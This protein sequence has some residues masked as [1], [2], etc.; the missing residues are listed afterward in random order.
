MPWHILMYLVVSVSNYNFS[1]HACFINIVNNSLPLPSDSVRDLIPSYSGSYILLFLFLSFLF[2]VFALFSSP[3]Y[4][5]IYIFLFATAARAI[6]AP[7]SVHYKYICISKFVKSLLKLKT[8]LFRYCRSTAHHITL[9][10][11]TLH[12]PLSIRYSHLGSR[13]SSAIFPRPHIRAALRQLYQKVTSA[14][15]S[16]R[17]T[18]MCIPDSRT[19]PRGVPVT[20]LYINT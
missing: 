4:L 18:N 14:C 2:S 1:R 17:R 16:P 7:A 12:Q 8:H 10:H 6:T 11:L 13:R 20:S 9:H 19:H 3:P 5:L 15:D